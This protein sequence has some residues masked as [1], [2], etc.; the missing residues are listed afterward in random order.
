ML[1]FIPMTSRWGLKRATFF[2]RR[3]AAVAAL[4]AGLLAS[5][6]DVDAQQAAPR[7]RGWVGI[8]MGMADESV[9]VRVD[10]VIRGSPAEKA[11]VHSDDRVITVDGTAVR[12]S[13]DV[14]RALGLHAAGDTAT[15]AIS[16]SGKPQ[17]LR[18]VLAD[19]PSVDAILRMDHVGSPAPAWIGLEPAADFPGSLSALSGRVVILDFWATWCGPCRDFAPVL[20]RWQSR[21]GAQG[22]AVLGITP[23]PVETASLYKERLDLKYAMA[24]DPH[25]ATS[26]TYGVSA[27]PTLFVIDKRGVVREV[28][29]GTDSEQ[30]ARIE[31]LINQLLAEPATSH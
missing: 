12:S 16:R 6:D 21:Y 5:A 31:A 20:S 7:G 24:S 29:V 27:L 13:H 23:D 2:A 26:S 25:A 15:L 30:D 19:Y 14:I 10:H 1:R 18:I 4:V 8:A 3:I 17:Q 28:V 9:G 11:G 22:L